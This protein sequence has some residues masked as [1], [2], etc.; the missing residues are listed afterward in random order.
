MSLDER[1]TH[2]YQNGQFVL[3]GGKGTPILQGVRNPIDIL[4]DIPLQ[5]S[6]STY[7]KNPTTAIYN[8]STSSKSSSHLLNVII[9]KKQ[10]KQDLAKFLHGA[11][12]SPRYSTLKQAIKKNFL[13]SF[14]GLTKNLLNKHLPPSIATKLGH[15]RQEKQHLQ[16]TSQQQSPEAVFFHP[17][18]PK[19]MM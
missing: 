9:R 18:N 17:K 14:P 1:Y 4:W 5:K 12:F 6:S 15:L 2:G 13:S 16:S 7:T 8:S 10:L 3:Q 11:L 19:L